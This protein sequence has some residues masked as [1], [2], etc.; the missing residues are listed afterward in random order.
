MLRPEWE[1]DLLLITPQEYDLLPDGIILYS[2]RGERAVKGYD[3][4]YWSTRAGHLEWGIATE[5]ANSDVQTERWPRTNLE[6]K[7]LRRHVDD[8]RP[9]P[10]K[11]RDIDYARKS[12]SSTKPFGAD[13]VR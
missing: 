5:W 12:P 10:F 3:E 2:L 1:Q 7:P 4:I 13:R 6:H 8:K 9:T 11:L